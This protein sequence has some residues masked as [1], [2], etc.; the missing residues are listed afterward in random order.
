MSTADWTMAR[1]RADGF[2]SSEYR[3]KTILIFSFN[4]C[5]ICAN[6]F[7]DCKVAW[8]QSAEQVVPKMFGGT[9]RWKSAPTCVYT[10]GD[11]FEVRTERVAMW[12]IELKVWRSAPNFLN[13]FSWSN[14]PPET[15]IE[16]LVSYRSNRNFLIESN[17]DRIE[18]AQSIFL[19]I[20][21]HPVVIT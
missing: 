13:P 18:N 14:V 15:L 1:P 9:Q 8:G 20:I 10:W 5:C 7:P 6:H 12:E 21:F 17:N 2:K 11:F 19:Q 4:S 16:I 3:E